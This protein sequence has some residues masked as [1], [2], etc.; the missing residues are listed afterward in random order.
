MECE[1]GI[2]MFIITKWTK[3]ITDDGIDKITDKKLN[4]LTHKFRLLD[5][6][7]IVYAYGYS[8]SCDD[9][10]AFDPLDYC[11]YLYGVTEIQYKNSTTGL[12]ETL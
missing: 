11:E 3:N 10:K 4:G 9:D 12:Y 6:D 1:R 2:K 5:D 7:G 8:D